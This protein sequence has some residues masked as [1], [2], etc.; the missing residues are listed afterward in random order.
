MC[1][2]G[3]VWSSLNAPGT[4]NPLPDPFVEL[5]EFPI[6]TISP[7]PFLQLTCILPRWGGKNGKGSGKVRFFMILEYWDR[8]KA[9][10][11]GHKLCFSYFA[12][13]LPIFPC[14]ACFN[15]TFPVPWFSLGM[16]MPIC[17]HACALSLSFRDCPL[18]RLESE[19]QKR[20]I[21]KLFRAL[22]SGK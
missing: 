13:F 4:E 16:P 7:H 14:S 10:P 11:L 5:R 6:L 9:A 21:I 1:L 18:V 15:R 22:T 17:P 12:L 8:A 3:C 20:L 2:K 19:G